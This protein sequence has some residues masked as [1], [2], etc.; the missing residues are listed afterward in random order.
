[1]NEW[2]R[3]IVRVWHDRPSQSGVYQGTAFF[4]AP[5]YLITAKHVVAELAVEKIY[6]QSDS[7][8]W[9]EGGL[10]KIQNPIFHP[11]LDVAVL[12]LLKPVSDVNVLALA[13]PAQA[14]LQQGQGVLLV[15]YS[16]AEGGL[17][18][19]EVQISAYHGDYDLEVVHTAIDKGMSGGPVVFDGELVGITRAKD[20][21]HTYLIPLNSFRELVLTFASSHGTCAHFQYITIP[22]LLEL[23]EL[24]RSA[25][26]SNADV[27][28]YLEKIDSTAIQ[29]LDQYEYNLLF[30][31]IEILSKKRYAPPDDAPLLEFMEYCRNALEM[32]LPAEKY[33]AIQ[34][35]QDRLATR[36]SIDLSLLRGKLL[37]NKMA[38]MS[39]KEREAPKLLLKIEPKNLVSEDFFIV[40]AWLYQEGEFKP[41]EIKEHD[42]HRSELEAILPILIGKT[43]RLLGV[44]AKKLLIEFVLPIQLFDWNLIRAQVRA[45]PLTKSLG[46]FYPLAVR[47]WERIY[48]NDYDTVRYKWPDKWVRRP[49]STSYIESRQI[50]TADT[51]NICC[52]T[53]YDELGED[54][55]VFIALFSIL[56]TTSQEKLQDIFG[57]MLAA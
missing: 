10:R 49:N 55:W 31:V 25:K 28:S 54:C 1:M 17:E 50:Y 24:L 13:N 7:G 14:V 4:I 48:H 53:L 35:W 19:P 47:S 12:P 32:Q 56:P 30:D 41:Q 38:E 5:G 44:E 36:L 26:I 40:R 34:G 43:A 21:A 57:T 52:E 20:D 11:Y 42:Y 3:S 27:L 15:G 33:S 16:T 18:T 29:W 37:K 51:E 45:G 22:E 46:T 8:A 23:K 2:K 6:L 39:R 9:I